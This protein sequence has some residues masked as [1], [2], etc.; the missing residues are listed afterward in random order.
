M[1]ECIIKCYEQLTNPIFWISIAQ[2]FFIL[3]PIAPIG[4]A[5]IESFIPAIPLIVIVTWNV[6]SFGPVL[7]FIY[8]WIGNVV[9]S[10]LVFSFFRLIGEKYFNKR[11]EKHEVYNRFKE[12]ILNKSAFVLFFISTFPF[13]PSSIIN[14]VYGFSTFP[15]LTFISM[16][17]FG[18]L[19]MVLSLAIFGQLF[20]NGLERNP[21]NLVYAI[22]IYIILY[23]ISHYVFKKYDIK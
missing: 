4:L 22:V 15:K 17:S 19:I 23:L 14:M 9:G 3:G 7:G 2:S 8:S 21:I 5:L 18:K 12:K 1:L 6:Y 11:L 10:I 16:I 13:T 20:K